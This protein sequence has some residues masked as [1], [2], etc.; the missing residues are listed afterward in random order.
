[1]IQPPLQTG[2]TG[3]QNSYRNMTE[4]ANRL[5]HSGIPPAREAATGG[6]RPD[7]ATSLV[8]MMTAEHIFTASAKV[9]ST[10]D[11]ALGTLLDA[12]A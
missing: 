9:V 6:A 12:T 8:E 7:A 5:V 11:R 3:M 2:L 4:A 10:S 1:M